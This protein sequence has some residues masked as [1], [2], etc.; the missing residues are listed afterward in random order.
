VASAAATGRIDPATRRGA[1]AIEVAWKAAPARVEWFP[2]ADPALEV[3]NVAVATEG[4]RTRVTFEAH[5]FEGQ[6][7]AANDLGSLVVSTDARGSRR[8]VPVRIR[9][10]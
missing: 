1:F 10:Q 5:V 6:Q 2:E 9:L 7:L 4:A 8:G 3:S